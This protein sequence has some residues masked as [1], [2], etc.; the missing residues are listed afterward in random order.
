MRTWRMRIACW[1]HK[2]RNTQSEHAIIIAV[3]L[4]QCLH[5]I[6]SMLT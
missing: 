2:A 5:E 4:Q 1:I 3:S 6:A